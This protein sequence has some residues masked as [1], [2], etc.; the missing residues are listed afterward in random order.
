VETMTHYMQLLSTNQPWHLPAFMA[1]P[2]IMAETV[3]ITELFILFRSDTSTPLSPLRRVNQVVGT[4]LGIYFLGVF[5]YLLFTA[6]I[7]LTVNGGWRGPG[8]VIAVGFYLAGVIPLFGIA[9]LELGAIARRK[10]A[11]GKM[12]VHASF[13]GLFLGVAHIAMIFGM[14]DPNLLMPTMAGL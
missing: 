4:I 13:V 14:L 3:A 8:D 12:L 6:A 1:L 7:P 10:S 11:R 9:L 5:V 2:V